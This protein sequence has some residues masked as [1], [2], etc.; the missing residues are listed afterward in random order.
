MAELCLPIQS[1]ALRGAESEEMVPTV[2]LNLDSE[3]ISVAEL[4]RRTLIEQLSELTVKG[5][6]DA[7]MARDRIARQYLTAAEIAEQA[8]S[9]SVRGPLAPDKAPVAPQ[10]DV[11]HEVEKAW[12][13]FERR[14]FR[15]VVD[16]QMPT[17]LEDQLSLRPD[18]K[19]AFMRLT[20]LVGG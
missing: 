15:L 16:G 14:A 5:M 1:Y 7:V 3:R 18:S 20:P 10:F 8:Q 4:I 9:G 11:D 12:R 13:G 17:G 6:L 19:I 2:Q